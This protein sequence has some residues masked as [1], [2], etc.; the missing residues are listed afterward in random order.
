MSG[1]PQPTPT[2]PE[3]PRESEESPM[4]F[5]PPA[6]LHRQFAGIVTCNTC[7]NITSNDCRH[8]SNCPQPLNGCRC[9]SGHPLSLYLE[10]ERHE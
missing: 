7:N 6:R 2:L 4:V 5:P 9:P 10:R 1:T 8:C 3:L